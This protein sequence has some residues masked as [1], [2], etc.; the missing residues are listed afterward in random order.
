MANTLAPEILA[1]AAGFFDGEGSISLIPYHRTGKNRKHNKTYY[2]LDV[3]LSNTY[4]PAIVWLKNNFGGY[5]F[6]YNNKQKKNSS[7]IARWKIS[8]KN[9]IRFL[10][11][12]L[13]YLQQKKREAEIA[14]AFY[15]YKAKGNM[16]RAQNAILIER[17]SEL[18]KILK[19]VRKENITKNQNL[20]MEETK[21]WQIHS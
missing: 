5:I 11:M 9:A 14:F 18:C 7:P 12:V 15:S 6:V 16:K 4:F 2:R 10:E 8:S 20:L 17:Q 19:L 21:S 3:V 13:P 1:Y